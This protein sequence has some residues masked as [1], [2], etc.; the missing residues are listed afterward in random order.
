[1]GNVITEYIAQEVA[2]DLRVLLRDLKKIIKV[3]SMYPPD[4]PLPAKMR[5]SFGARFIELTEKYNGFAL[6]IRADRIMYDKEVVYEDGGADET[7][8]A[9]FYDAG[10]I[11]LEFRDGLAEEE[12]NTFLDVVKS[13]INDRSVDR[14]LVS[15]L[16]QEQFAGIRFKTV[17]DLTL[18]E[19]QTGDLIREMYPQF[20]DERAMHAQFDVNTITLDDEPDQNSERGG[21]VISAEAMEDA[22]QMGLT[23]DSPPGVNDALAR[24]LTGSFVVDDEVRAEIKKRREE[25]ALFE[26]YR[27][28]TRILEEAL[29]Y[30]DDLQPFGEAVGIC[31]KTLDQLLH[32]GAFA[33]AAGFVHALK[34]RQQGLA[35]QKPGYAARLA[36][37]IRRA[38]DT[39]RIQ[40]LTEFIN[41]QEVIDTAS[42]EIYL[43]SLGWESL[44]YI[45]E[46]LGKL[47]SK[48]ARLMVCDYLARCGKSHVRIIGNGVRDKRW[49][50]A[51]NTV[52]ILGQIGGDEILDYLAM[53]TTHCDPRV[54]KET[55]TA[56]SK[57]RSDR[58]TDILGKFLHDAD[59]DV[60]TAALEILARTGGRKSFEGMRDI[61]HSPSFIHR[62]SEEQEQL[63]I[64]YSRLGGAEA[65]GYLATLAGSFSLFHSGTRFHLRLSALQA[66]AHNRSEEAEQLILQYTRS[67]RRWLREAAAA[68][69]NQRRRIMHGV[70]EGSDGKRA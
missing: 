64:I 69:L 31:E 46:M 57:L 62:P 61:V 4:N 2:S 8:A 65:T 25:N 43:E 16:W 10:V 66:L 48:K 50:V 55:I 27:S 1:M 12:L 6:D 20:G 47:V 30:W 29:G 28:I 45:M 49:Y 34:Q 63:L 26:P 37:F 22:R 7:L 42:V 33:A 35:A 38:G 39:Q 13:Y 40:Q 19:Y 67:S 41:S 15:L 54:R 3:L 32:K 70:S 11:F 58:A 56:L 59:P 14:D 18:N 24:L 60:R 36:D 17:E 52:M 9:F 51:R 23:L 5:V 68:A 21:R 53:T 44:P